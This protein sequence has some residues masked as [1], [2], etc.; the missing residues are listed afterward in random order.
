MKEFAL[1][2]TIA[3]VKDPTH[4]VLLDHQTQVREPE[5]V[6]EKH[7]INIPFIKKLTGEILVVG[8]HYLQSSRKKKYQEPT[9]IPPGRYSP[10]L[11]FTP[12]KRHKNTSK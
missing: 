1:M 9:G 8:R 7:K 10:G 3:P 2:F 12:D 4:P 11:K 6:E 5:T